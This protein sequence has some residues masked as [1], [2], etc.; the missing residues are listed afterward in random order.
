MPTS[1]LPKEVEKIIYEQLPKIMENQPEVKFTIWQMLSG[2][3][4]SKAETEDRFEKLLEQI[5]L[6]EEKSERKFEQVFKKLE[7]NDRKFDELLKE[8]RNVDHRIDRTIGALGSRWGFLMEE[9]FREAIKSVLK[10]FTNT[11]VERY[12]GFDNEGIVFGAPDQVEIDVVIK[13]GELW[14][15]E[16][17]SSVSRADTYAFNRKTEFYEKESGKKIDRKAIVSPMFEPGARQ[18]AEK[19]NIKTY[20]APEH[21]NRKKL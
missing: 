15:M 4:A 3:F 13:D 18:L 17:K 20:T 14:L 1:N 16:I 6:Q 12:L 21:I 19:M 11:K 2:K 8:I 5:R 9:T 7:E 10:N